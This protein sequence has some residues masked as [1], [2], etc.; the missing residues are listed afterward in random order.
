M[1]TAVILSGQAR[2]FARCLPSLAWAVF[3]KLED[4]HFFCSV[5]QDEDAASI[6]LLRTKYPAAPV[7]IEVIPQPTLAEPS[8]TLAAHAP[9]A[10]TP[11]KTP[12][13][14]PLQG[15]LRQL[16]H[17]SRAYKFAMEKGAGGCDVVVRCRPD[18]N[19][20][21]FETPNFLRDH[22][23]ADTWAETGAFAGNW[24]AATK[25]AITPWWG[26]YGRIGVNDRFGLFGTAAAKAYFEAYDNLPAMLAD[27]IPFHPETLVGAALERAGCTISR[28]LLAEFAMIRKN[29]E[30]EHMQVLPGEWAEWV[31]HLSRQ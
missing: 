24:A 12:G 10:I 7:H 17:N 26:S 4:P 5:A 14:G 1:K 20:A 13:V 16:W 8:V 25:L 29:G 28:T 19:F 9:Y 15:I 22:Y 3:S 31:A 27:G 30:W 6:E 23:R 2:T 11:T 18:L 21:S